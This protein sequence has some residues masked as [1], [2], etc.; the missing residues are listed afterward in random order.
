MRH[1]RM[2][3][4]QVSAQFPSTPVVA[5]I[6]S[7]QCD[8]PKLRA[9]IP[10]EDALHVACSLQ[11]MKDY[12]LPLLNPSASIEAPIGSVV[13]SVEGT[14]ELADPI[15]RVELPDVFDEPKDVVF[16]HL[17]LALA[18]AFDAPIALIIASNGQRRAWESRCG[19][20]DGWQSTNEDECDRSVCS[21]IDLPDSGLI[22]GDIANVEGFAADPFLIERGA[23]F[24]AGAPLKTAEGETIGS[25]CVLDTRPREL[26]ED[27]AQLLISFANLVMQAIE[28]HSEAPAEGL[29]V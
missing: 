6:L 12:L 5:C 26:S 20:P 15:E 22:V 1:L 21:T 16:N 4:H 25:L 29:T 24:Y 28:L 18:R 8:L 3:C 27:R 2:K 10:S 13:S 19:L 14:G 7:E 17:T 23:R 11:L 9:R